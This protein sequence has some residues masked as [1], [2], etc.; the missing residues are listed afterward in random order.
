MRRT[1]LLLPVLISLACESSG[2]LTPMPTATATQAPTPT[3]SRCEP[4]STAQADWIR[5][6]VQGVQ[7]SNDIGL[8][9]AVRSADYVRVWFVAAMITGP[10]MEEGVGPGVWAMGG[11]EEDPNGVF[12]AN[13]FALEFSDWGDGARTDAEFSMERDGAREAEA[14]ALAGFAR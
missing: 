13:A 6:G 9:F 12:S 8:A 4:A 3:P 10:G 14:C 2:D 5:V 11:E 1:L 7:Q